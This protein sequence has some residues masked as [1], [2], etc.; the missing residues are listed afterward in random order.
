MQN[1]NHHVNDTF[2]GVRPSESH[3]FT[4]FERERIQLHTAHDHK[5]MLDDALEVDTDKMFGSINDAIDLRLAI[6]DNPKLNTRKARTKLLLIDR[7][8]N[9]LGDIFNKRKSQVAT[10]HSWLAKFQYS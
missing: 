5:L 10:M 6:A 3:T 1:Q 9:Q 4:R 8:S 2:R 7:R